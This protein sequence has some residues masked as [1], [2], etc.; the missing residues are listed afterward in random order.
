LAKIAGPASETLDGIVRS[1]RH[2]DQPRVAGVQPL[3]ARK[4]LA[5]RMLK[6]SMRA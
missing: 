3:L 5:S 6:I 1:R 2:A 4:A